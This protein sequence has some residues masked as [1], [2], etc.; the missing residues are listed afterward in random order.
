MDRL[1]RKKV[2][3]PLM[4]SSRED[5]GEHGFIIVVYPYLETR[6]QLGKKIDA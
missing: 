6:V 3:E 5:A 4:N 2:K 1:R